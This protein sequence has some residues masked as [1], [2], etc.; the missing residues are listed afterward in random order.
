MQHM[1]DLPISLKVRLAKKYKFYGHEVGE[2]GRAGLK[3]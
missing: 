2:G 1:G 3:W